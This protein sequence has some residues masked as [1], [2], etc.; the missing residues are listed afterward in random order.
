MHI[1]YTD[2][3]IPTENV[4]FEEMYKKLHLH[5]WIYIG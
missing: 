5:V 1:I 2:G 3:L 4:Q